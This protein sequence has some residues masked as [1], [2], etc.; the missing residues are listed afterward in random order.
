MEF[1]TERSPTS[2]EFSPDGTL[3]ASGFEDNDIRIWDVNSGAEVRNLTGHTGDVL[4][5][6]FSPDG[7]LLASTSD[8]KTVSVWNTADGQVLHIFEGYEGGTLNVSFS[9]DGTRLLTSSKDGEIKMW[10]TNGNELYALNENAFV[11]HS[12]YAP[13]GFYFATADFNTIKTWN[14][15]N[16][17]EVRAWESDQLGVETLAYSNDGQMLISGGGNGSIDLW[18]IN[19]ATLLKTLAGHHG[20]ITGILFS[21]DGRTMITSSSDGTVRFWNARP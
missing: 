12:V 11:L 20:T 4:D 5:I 2:V 9:P 14:A 16:G 19:T 8:D 3:I 1:S 17:K 13:D 6:A 10:D 7:T 18:D 21:S 15:T